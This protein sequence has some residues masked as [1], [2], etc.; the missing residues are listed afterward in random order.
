MKAKGEVSNFYEFRV[1]NKQD[2]HRGLFLLIP[3]VDYSRRIRVKLSNKAL[4]RDTRR[5][6]TYNRPC[7]RMV[8]QVDLL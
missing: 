7:R 8:A 1:R 6:I 4:Y 2:R 3:S 5:D